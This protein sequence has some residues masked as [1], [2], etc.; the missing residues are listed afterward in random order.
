[1]TGQWGAV[2][3]L[4]AQAVLKGHS[5]RRSL[6]RGVRGWGK[7]LGPRAF[8]GAKG[9]G[10]TGPELPWAPDDT[11]TFQ[12]GRAAEAKGWAGLWSTGLQGLGLRVLA[13]GGGSP[14]ASGRS[15]QAPSPTHG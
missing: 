12:S 15:P 14:S 13:G 6:L 5:D 9:V 11:R 1:M 10:I 7:G 8:W 2:M 3:G 4:L